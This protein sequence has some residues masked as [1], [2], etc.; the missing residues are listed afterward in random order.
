VSSSALLVSLTY[1]FDTVGDALNQARLLPVTHLWL[2]DR[3]IASY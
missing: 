1:P 2:A 3:G